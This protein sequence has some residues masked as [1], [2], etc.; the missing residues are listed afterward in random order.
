MAVQFEKGMIGKSVEVS[1]VTPETLKKPDKKDDSKSKSE[2]ASSG[3]SHKFESVGD[4]NRRRQ[5]E[6]QK[7]IDE[8]MK[9]EDGKL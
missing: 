2:S 4:M 1:H 7:L 3:D 5:A 6:R 9:E 8:M